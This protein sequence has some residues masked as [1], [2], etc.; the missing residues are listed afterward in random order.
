MENSTK[1]LNNLL[2]AVEEEVQRRHSD[3]VLRVFQ[4]RCNKHNHLG[5]CNCE[6]CSLLPEYV[7]AKRYLQH[8]KRALNSNWEPYWFGQGPDPYEKVRRSESY[9]KNLKAQKDNLKIIQ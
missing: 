5:S 1:H 9:I 2:Q 6:Y 8:I 4:I 3:I 7:R